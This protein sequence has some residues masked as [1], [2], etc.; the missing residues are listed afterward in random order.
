MAAPQFLPMAR[1]NLQ[2]LAYFIPTS[3][4]EAPLGKLVITLR[5]IYK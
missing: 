5:C 3:L 2:H 1:G 4:P